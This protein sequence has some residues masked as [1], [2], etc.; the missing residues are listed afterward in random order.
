MYTPCGDVCVRMCACVSVCARVRACVHVC[1]RVCSFV[2]SELNLLFRIS[3]NSL[4]THTLYTCRFTL[5][6]VMW[7]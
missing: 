1:A 6:F 3:A 4:I 5:I 2:I 7:D